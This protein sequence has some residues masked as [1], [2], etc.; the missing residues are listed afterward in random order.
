MVGMPEGD[1]EIQPP[2]WCGGFEAIDA[3]VL[4]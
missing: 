2:R 4:I 1:F 3:E